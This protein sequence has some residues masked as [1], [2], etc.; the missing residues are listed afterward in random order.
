MLTLTI[1]PARAAWYFGTHAEHRVSA[2]TLLKRTAVCVALQMDD[3][4][5][6]HDDKGVAIAEICLWKQRHNRENL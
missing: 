6:A 5:C 2:W 3:L 4:R 1:E